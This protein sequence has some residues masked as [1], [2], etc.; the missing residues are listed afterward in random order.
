MSVSLLRW[1]VIAGLCLVAI[2]PARAEDRATRAAQKHF[3]K[4]Q[5]LFSLGKFELALDEYQQA[6]DAKPLGDFLYNIAQC[7]RNL[8][9]Y[10]QAIF[11][12]KKYLKEKPDAEDRAQVEK[13]IDELE[14]K[15]ERGEGQKLIQKPPPPPP[16][17]EHAD[18]TPIYK[19]WWFWTGVAV[20][21]V[22][23]GVG[24]Y[25]V[26]KSGAPATDL[27]NIGRIAW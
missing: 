22:A 3:E 6:Y 12:F 25:E 5:K 15:K 1:L 13:F 24:I 2:A 8:S 14:D 20:V 10:D 19:K 27:G 18:T 11:S 23:G 16:P 4:A 9:D 7:Y 26:T 17:A 21:G